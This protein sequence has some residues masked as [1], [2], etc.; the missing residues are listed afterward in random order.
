MSFY[1]GIFNQI[2][3]AFERIGI[4]NSG[5][6]NNN[7]I[8]TGEDFEIKADGREG[9]FFLD[10]GN[11]W[12]Q[13]QGNVIDNF[14]KI[15]HSSPSQ[16]FLSTNTIFTNTTGVPAEKS[17]ITVDLATDTYLKV[18][19]I[20][21]DKA[22][23]ISNFEDSYLYFKQVNAAKELDEIRQDISNFKNETNV[24]IEN[25]KNGTN[26]TVD[27]FKNEINTT[28]NNFEN[29]I[30]TTINNFEDRLIDQEKFDGRVKAL[31]SIDAGNKIEDINN[32]I[33]I[34]SNFSNNSITLCG[35]IGNID[36]LRND[37]K[38]E[39]DKI[40]LKESISA[41]EKES[42]ICDYINAIKS[43]LEFLM[44]KNTELEK[45]IT[46]LESK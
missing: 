12:I 13:L 29:E 46:E 19:N 25:F 5:K 23:H 20:K 36:Y 38:N 37:G 27:N 34:R 35:G 8:A 21:Y 17:L 26:T 28:I 9:E 22:G 6:N 44:I 31:E 7:F 40:I 15:Y 24:T 32:F 4:K 45:R 3:N 41:L 2:S 14:C 1:G 39:E 10:T 30:N 42:T 18:N 16:N 43:D 11:Q 33:G